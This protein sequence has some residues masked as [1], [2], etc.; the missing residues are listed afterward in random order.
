MNTQP[1]CNSCGS[2]NIK[3]FCPECGQSAKELNP[4]FFH[5]VKSFLEDTLSFDSKIFKT[6][7]LLMFKPG[8]LSKEYTLGKRAQYVYPSRL[9]VFISVICFTIISLLTLDKQTVYTM[10]PV[11]K[12]NGLIQ[13]V[14]LSNDGGKSIS[15]F[16]SFLENPADT[17]SDGIVTPEDINIF[18]EEYPK[19]YQDYEIAIKEL[20]DINSKNKIDIDI[21]SFITKCL[22]LLIPFFAIILKI[23]YPKQVFYNQ[24]IYLVHNHIA[25]LIIITLSLLIS[26]L[27]L[28]PDSPIVIVPIIFVLS[29]IYIL[30]SS[31]KFYLENKFN[32]VIK[33]CLSFVAY[34][35]FFWITLNIITTTYM[36]FGQVYEFIFFG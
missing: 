27:G 19:V 11:I 31:Y 21:F 32:T 25:V 33:Y 26:S 13:Y 17:D 7:K 30:L 35:G 28:I 3:N 18:K 36:V 6:L 1:K 16:G 22:M 2:E 20:S 15:R 24:I 14:E 4:D 29:S 5:L 23:F 34:V 8:L 9:Y 10:T 12:A